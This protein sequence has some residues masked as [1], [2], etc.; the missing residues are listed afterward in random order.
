MFQTQYQISYLFSK[1]L[2]HNTKLRNSRPKVSNTKPNFVILVQKL[3]N[4]M[5]NFVI[6]VQKVSNTTKFRIGRIKC[7]KHKTKFRKSKFQTQY[8]ISR[9]KSFKKFRNSRPNTIPNFVF[10]VQNFRIYFQKV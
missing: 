9:P 7:F 4:T 8:S 1:S 5:P 10:L 2:E 6:L 3:S